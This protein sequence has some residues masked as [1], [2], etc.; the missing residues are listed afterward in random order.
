MTASTSQRDLL[1]DFDLLSRNAQ[2]TLRARV[3]AAG[4]D[5]ERVQQEV[6]AQLDALDSA[7]ATNGA[8]HSSHQADRAF[9]VG[10]ISYLTL[11]AREKAAAET[12]QKQGIMDRLRSIWR[13]GGK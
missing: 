2:E 4:G 9:L 3:A 11:L 12:P 7:A 8:P 5:V 13:P 6:Q 10:Q 1:G